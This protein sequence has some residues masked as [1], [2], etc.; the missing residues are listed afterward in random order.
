MDGEILITG[1][2]TVDTEETKIPVDTLSKG[3]YKLFLINDGEVFKK[4]FTV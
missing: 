4:L 1:A 3:S 2:L